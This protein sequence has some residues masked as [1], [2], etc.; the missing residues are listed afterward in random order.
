M[1]KFILILFAVFTQQIIIAQPKVLVDNLL[2]CD[3]QVTL[4]ASSA[5]DVNCSECSVTVCIPANSFNVPV[6]ITGCP[7]ISADQDALPTWSEVIIHEPCGSSSPCVS[8]VISNS[9]VGCY[10]LP[11]GTV[12]TNPCF[13][14]PCTTGPAL[15]VTWLTGNDLEI[16]W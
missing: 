8:P 12:T 9:P 4:H 13:P 10:G 6:I 1:K 5:M 2:G 3:I 7:P 15:Y 16:S 11:P 14:S